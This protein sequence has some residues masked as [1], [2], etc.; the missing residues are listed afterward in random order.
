MGYYYPNEDSTAAYSKVQWSRYMAYESWP[1]VSKSDPS[2]DFTRNTAD[3]IDVSSAGTNVVGGWEA[4]VGEAHFM[5]ECSGKGSCDRDLGVCQCYDGYTGGACQRTTCPNDCSGHGVC[6]T[7][8]E[9]ALRA[10]NKKFVESVASNN[11]YSGITSPY[12]YRLWDADQNSACVCDV[13]YSGIDCSLRD[14]PK[15]DDPLTTT[16][17]TCG[18]RPCQDEVQSFSVDGAQL[19]P[20]TYY[21]TVKDYTGI[22]FKTEEFKLYSDSSSNDANWDAHKLANEAAVKVALES[23]P[24]NLTGTVTVSS[25]A[26]GFGSGGATPKDQYRMSVTF[27]GKSGNVPEMVLGWTG[28]SNPNTR[29][30]FVFQPGQPVQ[31][32]VVPSAL[33]PSIWIKIGVYP[34]DPTL[35]GLE[36]Y[37]KSSCT[38]L[39]VSTSAAGEADVADG[40][41]T[42]LNSIAAIK[43]TFGRPFI[44]D[45][46]V[47][48]LYT[49][50]AT[51]GYNVQVAFPDK[52]FG[53]AD[54]VVKYY[55]DDTC[56]E[57]DA[58]DLD[59]FLFNDVTD[60]NKE[61]VTC[62]NRGLCD[63]ET[64]LCA[65]FT[66]Y[67]GVSCDIQSTL[68]A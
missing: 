59:V 26:T 62:S 5:V 63:F 3:G 6:R 67:T 24:N 30:A 47:V 42:A 28:T 19:V 34:L 11:Y 43:Q 4:Q 57:N 56:A 27:S 38:E 15:G 32:A 68:A 23:L 53:L 52:Q 36:T 9:I 48:A 16:S 33:G 49:P 22:T 21:L 14:C 66:G 13:G 55:P 12:E 44:R 60:G 20:G 8:R 46:N 51:A 31:R 54:I 61:Y 10:Y 2:A 29:R 65:C 45:A 17:P 18:G 50:G 58:E 7:V 1:T 37:W 40:F 64:G 39:S 41:A 25:T 35:Y